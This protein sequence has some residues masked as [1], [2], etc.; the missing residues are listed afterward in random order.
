MPCYD[1]L[2]KENKT[3]YIE[4]ED[5]VPAEHWNILVDQDNHKEAILC[6]IYN[7]LKR[8]GILQ[9]VIKSAQEAGQVDI[10]SHYEQHRC[11]D[12]M[13]I[14]EELSKY[15]EDELDIIREILHAQ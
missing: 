11:K 2:E 9:Q 8:L 4:K 7:E 6:A 15:S 5:S 12:V 3:I 1:G 14:T 10:E 13:R